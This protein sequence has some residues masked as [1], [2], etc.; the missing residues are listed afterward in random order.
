MADPRTCATEPAGLNLTVVAIT[1]W[2]TAISK[3]L[4]RLL[5]KSYPPAPSLLQHVVYG[6]RSKQIVEILKLE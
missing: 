2:N 1:V 6:R 3:G 4:A 5:G